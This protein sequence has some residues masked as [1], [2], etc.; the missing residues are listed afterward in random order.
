YDGEDPNGELR[1]LQMQLIDPDGN[2]SAVLAKDV[3]VLARP[4]APSGPAVGAEMLELLTDEAY[5]YREDANNPTIV[6]KKLVINDDDPLMNESSMQITIANGAAGED[7]LLFV[8]NN[9]F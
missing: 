4:N 3:L 8:E 2:A 6:G 9:R 1:H 7:V 5:I